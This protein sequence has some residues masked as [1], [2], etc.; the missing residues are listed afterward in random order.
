MNM[1]IEKD[2]KK[3]A[4]KQ[5]IERARKQAILR[6]LHWISHGLHYK[7]QP[8]VMNKYIIL[9]ELA[10][11]ESCWR[12]RVETDPDGE[13]KWRNRSWKFQG[14]HGL[15]RFWQQYSGFLF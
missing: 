6:G 14:L 8:F 5:E 2:K 3:Q 1:T 11:P 10:I 9:G 13:I 15:S 7:S 4:S 12:F